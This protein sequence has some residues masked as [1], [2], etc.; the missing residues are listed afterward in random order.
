MAHEIES[1]F[2]VNEVP[3]HGLGTLL[4]SPPTV[5]EAMREAGLDWTVTMREVRTVDG[6]EVPGVRAT[7]RESDGRVLGCVGTYYKPLQNAEAFDF[8]NP[9][10]AAGEATL[11]TAGSL[12]EGS[13]IWILAKL[14][15][16]PSVIV[17]GDEVNKYILLANAHDGSL[18]VRVGFVP[19]RVVCANT[20]ALAAEHQASKLLR[21]RHQKNVVASLTQL[22]DVMNTANASF[23][24]TAEQYRR[25]AKSAVVED[26]L[27]RYV[28]TVF[29]PHT[30]WKKAVVADEGD[31]VDD[32]KS[33][34]YDAVKRLFETGRG[35]NLPGVR[36]TMWAAY[37]AV[38]E[39]IGYERGEAQDTRVDSMW[40]RGGA[41]INARA[42]DTALAMAA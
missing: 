39:Y 16:D 25:L 37:N 8:F 26:D 7:V 24:A 11:E 22:H 23:E 13:R 2:S 34:V 20:L 27:K 15:R 30:T 5:A 28:K 6:A 40:F 31:E 41:R 42:L 32:S 1:M 33:R 18:T 10:L 19:I 12:R 9:F 38:T 29:A 14:A 3:W 4:D 36:G 35:A 17:P 21:I